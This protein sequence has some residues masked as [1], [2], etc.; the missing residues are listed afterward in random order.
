M[1]LYHAV[2]LLVIVKLVEIENNY[3]VNCKYSAFLYNGY[4][5]LLCNKKGTDMYIF[6]C[7]F[8]HLLLQE[9]CH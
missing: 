9:P 6:L 2:T 7:V 1:I 5:L 8:I 4:L 3:Y